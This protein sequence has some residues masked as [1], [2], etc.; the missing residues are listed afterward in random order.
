MGFG[1][2]VNTESRSTQITQTANYADSFNRAQSSVTTFGDVGNTTLKIGGGDDDQP[3]WEKVVPY[4]I[5]AVIVIAS[6]TL[7]RGGST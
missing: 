1:G 5:L 2:L 4:A 3:N 7:L 6:F